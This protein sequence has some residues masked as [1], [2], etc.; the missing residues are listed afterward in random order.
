[1]AQQ[2]GKNE[3]SQGE[4]GRKHPDGAAKAIHSLLISSGHHW[5]WSTHE[6]ELE[7]GDPIEVEDAL[8]RLHGLGLVHRLGEFA[9]PTRTAS[10]V[11]AMTL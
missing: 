6:I 9:W 5:P 7:I 4:S 8:A 1:M 3:D 10:A 2:T 11:D